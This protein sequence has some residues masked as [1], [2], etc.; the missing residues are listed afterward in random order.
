VDAALGSGRR[1]GAPPDPPDELERLVASASARPT[2]PHWLLRCFPLV[3]AVAKSISLWELSRKVPGEPFRKDPGEPFRK[4]PEQVAMSGGGAGGSTQG[5]AGDLG[6]SDAGS[7][8]AAPEVCLLDLC[9]EPEG[10]TDG[11]PCSA[12]SMDAEECRVDHLLNVGKTSVTAA[13][14]DSL[15]SPGE[16]LQVAPGE[17]VHLM[18]GLVNRSSC[19][20]F[21]PSLAFTSN[22]P[23]LPNASSYE[24]FDWNYVM[25]G[26]EV[27]TGATDFVV[28]K[29]VQVGTRIDFYLTPSSLPDCPQPSWKFSLLVQ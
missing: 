26:G 17:A 2:T 4:D 28:P 1:R 23:G 27:W 14:G 7:A 9:A 15:V 3:L 29:S 25:K 18:T 22:Y 6:T 10:T 20:N 24:S 13:S 5:E 19:T 8:G 16:T 21:S 11:L 12:Q